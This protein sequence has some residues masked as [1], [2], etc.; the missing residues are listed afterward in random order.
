M[1]SGERERGCDGLRELRGDGG[2]GGR[3]DQ[4]KNEGKTPGVRTRCKGQ[5][6]LASAFFDEA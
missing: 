5:N 3:G 2:A 1:F 4:I 6:R